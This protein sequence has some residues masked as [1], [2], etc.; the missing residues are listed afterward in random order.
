MN[1]TPYA[2]RRAFQSRFMNLRGLRHHV[3]E[4]GTPSADRPTLVMLHGWMDVGASFQFVVDALGDER[5]VIALDWRGFGL[6]AS[7]GSD[8]YWFP[9]YLGDL[10]ALLDAI[11]PDGAVDLLGHSMG[12]NVVMSYAGLRPARIRK[13]INLEGFGLPETRPEQAPGRLIA[14]LDELKQPQLLRPYASLVAVAER[15]IKT[16]PRLSPDKAAWLAGHWAEQRDGAWHILGDPAHKRSNPVLY[17]KAEILACWAHIEAP[18]LWVE[19]RETDV[20]KWWGNRYP[21]SEFLERLAVVPQV[22]QVC[23]DEAGHMLH[24]DQPTVLAQHLQAFLS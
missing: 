17:R 5:H 11:S 14:W 1:S 2:P 4:W 23:L 12:G 21:R 19:G 18:L 20:A 10:D 22:E 16:N 8:A 9:D 7:S 13:L 3:L 24:H 15:L 6:S